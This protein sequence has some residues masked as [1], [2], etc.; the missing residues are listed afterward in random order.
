MKIVIIASEVDAAIKVNLKMSSCVA[1]ENSIGK[2]V[3]QR[4]EIAV[5]SL[6]CSVREYDLR[7]P[8]R[9]MQL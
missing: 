5:A 1:I 4:G 6:D 3:S 2:P 9:K 7:T 8:H